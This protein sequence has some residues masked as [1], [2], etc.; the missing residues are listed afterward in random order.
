MNLSVKR[1]LWLAAFGLP[2]MLMTVAVLKGGRKARELDRVE[3]ATMTNVLVNAFLAWQKIPT[4]SV[5]N[6]SL[7]KFNDS[8]EVVTIG[9]LP[10]PEQIV[11]LR[12][13]TYDL[14]KCYNDSTA[15]SLLNYWQPCN[16][17]LDTNAIPILKEF[18]GAAWGDI[19]S[20]N[21]SNAWN[22]VIP[23]NRIIGVSTSAIR[24]EVLWTSNIG[25]MIANKFRADISSF[26]PVPLPDQIA[27]GVS[28][29]IFVLHPSPSQIIA[30][31]GRVLYARVLLFVQ[32]SA[33]NDRGDHVVVPLELGLYWSQL[34]K[35]W[36]PHVKG[37]ISTVDSAGII[38]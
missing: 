36:I 9:V 30:E 28:R 8:M 2:V 3:H 20:Q 4:D 16:W 7:T 12:K 17:S 23:R 22:K 38:F 11:S 27:V 32:Y 24:A 37:V 19:P 31:A 33:T 1:F 10:A 5:Q 15:T 25:E 26:S 6:L 14:L 34:D 13:T 29:S 18:A 35:R 21:V